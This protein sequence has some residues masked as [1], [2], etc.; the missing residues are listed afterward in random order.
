MDE[1]VRL[2]DEEKGWMIQQDESVLRWREEFYFT[3]FLDPGY[4][5]DEFTSVDNSIYFEGMHTFV[6]LEDL[7]F[8]MKMISN[9]AV[10]F[11]INHYVATWQSFIFGPYINL[12]PPPI[13][14][15]SF[16]SLF[17]FFQIEAQEENYDFNLILG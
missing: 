10:N 5:W 9:L 13:S 12:G 4:V 1:E 7:S 6:R 16:L 8:Q 2:K 3:K 14:R 11:S 15:N 17:G